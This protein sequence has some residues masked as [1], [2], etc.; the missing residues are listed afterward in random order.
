[1]KDR[2]LKYIE[3]FFKRNEELV[4]C[5]ED[6]LR[7]IDLLLDTIMAKDGTIFVCGN[8]GSAADSQ[9]IAGELLKSFVLKRR[10]SATL[11]KTLIKDWSREGEEIA[12]NLQ[13]GIKC[14]PLDSFTSFQTAFSNDCDND[15]VFA[16]LLSVLSRKGDSLISI[17]TSGNSRN[18]LLASKLAKSLGLNV[19]SLTGE[20]GGKIKEVADV[21]IKTPS[22][23]CWQIQEFHIRIYHLLCLVLES[24]KFVD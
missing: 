6:I 3:D 7:S 21:S 17:S 15:F 11:E 23:I 1:M 9:H 20:S 13:E 16:Q 10:V 2:S 19:I 5:R 8:G 12:N 22:S 18:C 24:E 14:I 4:C